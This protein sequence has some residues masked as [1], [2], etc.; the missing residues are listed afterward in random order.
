MHPMQI[1]L[2]SLTTWSGIDFRGLAFSL[3]TCSRDNI[4]NWGDIKQGQVFFYKSPKEPENMR[5]DSLP[6]TCQKQ[7]SG[8]KGSKEGE[9]D[10]GSESKGLKEPATKI[11]PFLFAK[12]QI[13]F[14]LPLYDAT[15]CIRNFLFYVSTRFLSPEGGTSTCSSLNPQSSPLPPPEIRI[16]APL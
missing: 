12:M 10:N 1:L 2:R 13:P 5:D 15:G 8:L 7:A 4:Y 9:T 16:G 6:Q 3:L 11:L 14:W